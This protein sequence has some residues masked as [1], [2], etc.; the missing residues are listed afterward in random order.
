MTEQVADAKPD[1][2][3]SYTAADRAWAEWIAHTLEANGHRCAV[4]AWDFR[5]GADFVVEM[6]KAASQAERTIA[7]LSRYPRGRVG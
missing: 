2:F 1:F 7:V 5:P 6:H 4:Q 3:V